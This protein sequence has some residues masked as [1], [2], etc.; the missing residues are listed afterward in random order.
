M[1]K[2]TL[3]QRFSYLKVVYFPL[4]RIESAV[5]VLFC[6]EIFAIRC[7]NTCDLCLLFCLELRRA[8]LVK[9]SLIKSL[10]L[11]LERFYL[12]LVLLSLRWIEVKRHQSWFCCGA[13]DGIWFG[14][15]DI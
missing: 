5:L 1:A 11:R 2:L 10:S 15:T 9:R 14:K 3:A 8:F 7:L 13:L 4:K 12:F 6:F